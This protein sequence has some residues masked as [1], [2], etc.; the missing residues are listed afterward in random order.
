[1][2]PLGATTSSKPNF[3][4]IVLALCLCDKRFN[5]NSYVNNF[6]I[7][8]LKINEYFTFKLYNECILC[9]T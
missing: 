4:Y 3:Y 2:Q 6:F 1:M 9:E 5:Q 8:L 7:N